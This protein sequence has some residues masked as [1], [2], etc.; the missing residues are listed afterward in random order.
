MRIKINLFRKIFLFSIF[1]VIFTIVLSFTLSISVSDTFY[2]SR[3]K[4]EITKIVA[5]VKKL[6]LDEDILEDYI[7]EVKNSQGINILLL[8]NQTYDDFYNYKSTTKYDEVEDGFH[9]GKL[10]YN[11]IM[12]LTYKEKLS[13][14]T[15]LFLSTSLSVMSSHRHEVYFLNLLA[16]VISLILSILISRGFSKKITKSIAEMNRVA[17]KITH[18]DFSEKLKIDTGD[19]LEELGDSINTMSDSLATSIENLKS[20][21]SNASHEL[22]TPIAV[23]NTQAQL[24]LKG[25]EEDKRKYYKAILKESNYMN[26]LVQSLLLLSK[27]SA[28]GFQIK[29]ERVKFLELLDES[30]EKYEFLELQKDIE[31]DIDIEDIVLCGDRKFLQIAINNIVQNALKYSVEGKTIKIYSK[32]GNIYFENEFPLYETVALDSL[33]QP[34]TRGNVAT[35]LN[36]E[37]SGLGLSLIK[38]IFELHNFNFKIEIQKN[39]FIFTLTYSS[40]N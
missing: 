27:L 38:K 25:T 34:F 9:I 4:R 32:D 30:I 2:I 31:W 8:N 21:V 20:F 23:I 16:L 39:L 35:E 37:G 40:H 17:K 18:L 10:S 12:L 14:N 36:I 13:D 6:M 24:L 1:L 29:D 33:M 15:T 26:E 3:K 11:H 22:K 5:D 19:E 28:V 7:D